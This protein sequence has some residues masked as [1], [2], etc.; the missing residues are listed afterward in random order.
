MKKIILSLCII[1]QTWALHSQIQSNFTAD[2][3]SGCPPF[4]VNFYDS[5]ASANSIVSWEWDFGN[6]N[7]S[8]LQ[9]PTALYNNPGS[10]SVHL[11]IQDSLGNYDTLIKSQYL[12]VFEK[13]IADFTVQRTTVCKNDS[14]QFTNNSYAGINSFIDSFTWDFG[15]GTIQKTRNPLKIYRDTGHFSVTL[16]VV[17]NNG[18]SDVKRVNHLVKV[19]DLPKIASISINRTVACRRPYTYTMQA[20]S[21]S[22]PTYRW[23]MGDGNHRN[24]NSQ[25]YT[26]NNAGAF[27]PLIR[28]TD[29]LGCT[30]DS[31]LPQ[32][33]QNLSITPQFIID[34]DTTVCQ[35]TPI[36]FRNTSSSNI[37][38]LLPIWNFGNG[39]SSQQE[40]PSVVYQQSGNYQVRLITRHQQ[41]N[42]RDTVLRTVKVSVRRDSLYAILSDSI[43]CKTPFAVNFSL[44]KPVQTVRW[45]L[46]QQAKDS[47]RSNAPQFTYQNYGNYPI[48]ISYRD[49]LGCAHTIQLPN[50]I[51]I[52]PLRT[53]IHGDTNGCIPYTSYFKIQ[54]NQPLNSAFTVWEIIS[55][56]KDSTTQIDSIKGADSLSYH[57]TKAGRGVI[58]A[59][60]MSIDSCLSTI[61]T[62][63][64][65]GNLSNPD[66]ALS[67]KEICRKDSLFLF[68]LTDTSV[69]KIH[70]VKWEFIPGGGS[71][72]WEDT[73]FLESVDT[74]SIRLTTTNYGCSDTI[75]KEDSLITIGN[76]AT[77]TMLLD[78]CTGLY[79]IQNTSE[80]YTRVKWYVN[81]TL[82]DSL[83]PV[84]EVNM[85][86]R[87]SAIVTLWIINDS[88]S[89]EPDTI[90]IS[91]S[92]FQRFKAGFTHSDTL[93]A[94]SL[95][96]F[97]QQYEIGETAQIQDR[98][99]LYVNNREVPKIGSGP[100]QFFA[101]GTELDYESGHK[102]DYV[103][104]I[105]FLNNGTYN[106]SMVAK[107]G[108][109]IDTVQK[110]ISI[111]GPIP[112]YE[113]ISQGA[114]MPVVLT[115]NAEIPDGHR[116]YW[117]M[118]N[119]DTLTATG[120]DS[121]TYTF[122]PDTG[123]YIVTYYVENNQG[124]VAWE[125]NDIA[126][127][128]P[129][130]NLSY[131]QIIGCDSSYI[132]LDHGINNVL[133]HAFLWE[134]GDHK[135][136]ILPK[137]KHQYTTD[138]NYLVYLYATDAEGC[139]SF[140]SLL[141]TFDPGKLEANFTVKLASIDCPP[142]ITQFLDS[143]IS[144]KS[145]PIVSYNWDFGDGSNATQKHPQKVYSM[146]GSY[147]VSLTITDTAGCTH[148]QKSTNE[149]IQVGGPTGNYSFYPSLGC[150][151]LEVKFTGNKDDE[152]YR[153]FWDL[154]D[155]RSRD[156]DTFTATYTTEG[157]YNP[158]VIISNAKGCSYALPKQSDQIDVRPLPT[159]DFIL[160]NQCV[161]EVSKIKATSTLGIGQIM[162]HQWIIDGQETVGDSILFPVYEAKVK[163]IQLTSIS[164]IG[165]KDSIIKDFTFYGFKPA[166][167]MF[168]VSF[169]CM[170]NPVT[171]KDS[172]DSDLRIV[173]RKWIHL[174]GTETA[175]N[176]FSYIPQEKGANFSTH[177]L[178]LQDSLGCDTLFTPTFNIYVGDTMPINPNNDLL[179]VSVLDDTKVE[180]RYPLSQHPEFDSYL[181]YQI[182]QQ[183]ELSLVKETKNRLDT[184][185][186]QTNLE[187]INRSYCFA[188][189]QR[190]LC[191][192]S[193]S[194]DQLNIHCTINL[195]GQ[196]DTNVSLLSWN[197]Y[198]GWDSVASYTIYQEKEGQYDSIAS[199]EGDQLNYADS[200]I[201]STAEFSFK[202]KAIQGGGNKQQSWSDTAQREPAYQNIVTVPHIW[203][204]T[205]PD[206]ESNMI[207]WTIDPISRRALSFYEIEQ[208]KDNEVWRKITTQPVVAPTKL[209]IEKQIDVQSHSYSYRI[210]TIDECGDSSTWS[211]IGKTILLQS[212]ASEGN[213]SILFWT[214]YKGWPE[215][216]AHYIIEEELPNGFFTELAKVTDKDTS[217]TISAEQLSCGNEYK[218]RITALRN[219]ADAWSA[220]DYQH[221][222]SK[223]NVSPLSLHSRIF[224]PTAFSPNNNMLNDSY[225]VTSLNIRKFTMRI[226]NRWGE[227]L[228]ETN[229][230]AEQWDGTYKGNTVPQGVYACII[231]AV[232]FD[233]IIHTPKTTITLLR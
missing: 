32:P 145:R 124:C 131:E 203:Q 143:S 104:A 9:Q 152:S 91:L 136:S 134:F 51:Q 138:S 149:Y 153:L 182:N 85:A 20:Q 129:K 118:G 11:I 225:Q 187:T 4:V 210:K 137:P 168:S 33:I 193:L 133:G 101:N 232:G 45:Q 44:S 154:G 132:Q 10:Y 226:F 144:N 146:P 222:E 212:K 161:N 79:S 206:N 150:T 219:N 48:N 65:F 37:P 167:K 218:H 84:F 106:V 95:V 181:L 213:K 185:H 27:Q 130:I 197:A 22:S 191:G 82:Q 47:S 31:L 160:Q 147:K 2:R 69:H 105:Y 21:S 41:S 128:A 34:S 119:G 14:L 183:N 194:K 24:G 26:Y 15:D 125:I 87:S 18:C 158:N 78:S 112:Q 50:K 60:I 23:I 8:T 5:S 198:T 74:L 200:L 66:F 6:G 12:T 64:A 140:D 223:S 188:T 54:S 70:N 61:E 151:P 40:S 38:S 141:V 43:S 216:V 217:F 173:S 57:F 111:S 83:S 196:T 169:L 114:C 36:T 16:Y 49:I 39:Q 76:K 73:L 120:I 62:S 211:N 127:K 72:K 99:F 180:M 88:I 53:S 139:R 94:P 77:Y 52:A 59:S 215:G 214:P 199:V 56:N 175:S 3:N 174:N 80:L 178:Y 228:F 30:A 71:T 100:Y 157:I 89:C 155:G 67:H 108:Q 122:Y 58:R 35:N 115:L 189:S 63:Y 13:P 28:I 68:N 179:Y 135:S 224:V 142:L 184:F 190:N 231:H 90:Y 148:T 229:D 109:C 164:D 163:T 55:S 123:I 110:N 176:P 113:I 162:Q 86:H 93:C 117:M 126:L 208:L 172:S 156:I 17:N 205:V 121:Y 102:S 19:N 207:S 92:N 204:A 192:A 29:S 221:I 1:L 46:T 75:Y 165:C 170:G 230:C 98:F 166:I 107:R 25:T 171:L 202:V 7:K 97:Y 116:A 186:T 81:D 177:K 227:L 42:C 195:Q 220:F 103:P 201:C 209:T 159:I 96:S 233:N